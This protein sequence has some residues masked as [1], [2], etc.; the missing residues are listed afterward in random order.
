MSILN[1]FNNMPLFL[2]LFI[3]GS[4]ATFLSLIYGRITNIIFGSYI[5]LF[6]SIYLFQI[7]KQL[8]II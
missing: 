4:K 5:I 1:N 2:F 6:F 8:L 3:T 7:S